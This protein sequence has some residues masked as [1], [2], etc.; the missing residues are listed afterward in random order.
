MDNFRKVRETTRQTNHAHFLK[1][2]NL[3]NCI[4]CMALKLQDMNYIFHCL[5]H[6]NDVPLCKELCHC[7]TRPQNFFLT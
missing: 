2:L 1:L 7:I 3:Y 6:K 5:V 4:K